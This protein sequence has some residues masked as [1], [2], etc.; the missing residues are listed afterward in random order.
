MDTEPSPHAF[1]APEPA[2]LSDLLPGYSVE[3]LIAVGGMGAVYRAVQN[4]L[5]RAVA[6]KILPQ[7][8]GADEAFRVQF[9]TEAK[10]MA[11]LNH[12]NLVGVYDF[13]NVG[14][15]L[16]IVMEFV[17]GESLYHHAYGHHLEQDSAIR[18][19]REICLGLQHAHENGVLHRDIKPSNI[20][21]DLQGHPKIVDFGLAQGMRQAPGK[22][23][24]VYGTPD[25]TAPEVLARSRTV[26]ARADI[27]S[28]GV[29]LHELLTGRVPASDPRSPSAIVSCDP[30]LDGVVRK[31]TYPNPELRY[32]SAAEMAAE[33]DMIAQTPPPRALRTVET[34]PAAWAPAGHRNRLSPMAG[35]RL[36][37]GAPAAGAAPQSSAP[38]APG[39]PPVPMKPHSSS[40]GMTI[41]IVLLVL[42]VIV[43]LLYA[44]SSG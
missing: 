21:L 33:L 8:L 3:S 15:L 17:E 30:R 44:A 32:T 2:V 13:G 43:L 1:Q 35:G 27:F 24:Q 11:L 23:E 42:A 25:Y 5:H 18:F 34:P 10:A 9:E 19:T 29:I 40:V 38:H 7:E 41:L 14:G 39:R 37:P 28:V 16:Y 26:D 22:D 12:P 20:L 36:S 6:I 31:A 4:S